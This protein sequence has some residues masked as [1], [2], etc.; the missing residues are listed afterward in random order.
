VLRNFDRRAFVAWWGAARSAPITDEAIDEREFERIVDGLGDGAHALVVYRLV[1]PRWKGVLA[2]RAGGPAVH[3]LVLACELVARRVQLR[4]S[5]GAPVRLDDGAI[6]AAER[7]EL[8]AQADAH[9]AAN[10]GTQRVR[11]ASPIR[12]LALEDVTR[13]EWSTL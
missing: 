11:T 5:V 3:T 9:R 8:S 4:I 10:V 7:A 12:V 2:A 1:T 13:G 6:S